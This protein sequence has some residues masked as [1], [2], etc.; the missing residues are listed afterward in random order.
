MRLTG[1]RPAQFLQHIKPEMFNI[2]LARYLDEYRMAVIEDLNKSMG[3]WEDLQVNISSV[4][5]PAAAAPTWAAYKGSYILSFAGNADNIIYFTAQVQHAY[6]Q[7]SNLEF[8]IHYVP[9]DNAAGNVRW[10]FTHSWANMGAAFPGET[11]VTTILATPEVTDQHTYGEIEDSLSGTG[12]EISSV[13][14]C[15][16]QREATHATDTYN[17]KAIYLT[18]LDF[19]VEFDSNGSR[20]LS[21]K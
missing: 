10:N 12:K 17:A 4:R 2:E 11:T 15:S 5:V 1:I 16:L 6:Q 7:G 13:L 20:T 19:H 14:L 3:V 18:A 8:H 9:E 21:T